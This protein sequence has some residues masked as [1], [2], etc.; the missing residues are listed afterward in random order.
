MNAITSININ[1]IHPCRCHSSSSLDLLPFKC[2][3][4][5]SVDCTNKACCAWINRR[6]SSFLFL[7]GLPFWKVMPLVWQICGT[8]KGDEFSN[9]HC[10]CHRSLLHTSSKC[11]WHRTWSTSSS[12]VW[13]YSAASLGALMVTE[14]ASLGKNS[15]L[16]K[17]FWLPGRLASPQWDPILKGIHPAPVACD[18]NCL[19]LSSIHWVQGVIMLV[20]QVADVATESLVTAGLVPFE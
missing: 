12:L 9:D 17:L 20:L 5:S 3:S 7:V 2:S 1:L 14:E 16:C 15:L 18:S 6:A 13:H 19:P 8:P 11:C 10:T 4:S